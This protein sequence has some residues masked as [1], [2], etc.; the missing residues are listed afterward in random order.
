MAAR[1]S[2]AEMFG[3]NYYLP[4]SAGETPSIPEILSCVQ[5]NTEKLDQRLNGAYKTLQ[6]RIDFSQR[7]PLLTAQRLWLQYR[8]ANCK[9][10]GSQEGTSAVRQLQTAECMRSMTEDRAR[11]LQNAKFEHGD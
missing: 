10:Y 9:F 5:A 3:P 8:D 4:C 1:P 7:Q 2:E 11:E 6:G